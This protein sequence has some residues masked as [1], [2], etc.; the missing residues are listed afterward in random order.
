MARGFGHA[1]TTLGSRGV[2]VHGPAISEHIPAKAKGEVVDT[3][4]AGDAFLG[5]FAAAM[6]TRQ[7]IDTARAFAG[8]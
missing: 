2:L 6:P 3:S 7:E 5:S 8:T 4:G 1:I